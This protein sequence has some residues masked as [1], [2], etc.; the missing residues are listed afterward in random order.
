MDV[1]AYIF[2]AVEFKCVARYRARCDSLCLRLLHQIIVTLTRPAALMHGRHFD[3]RKAPRHLAYREIALT[4]LAGANDEMRSILL[5]IRVKWH[6]P[7]I[8]RSQR[9]LAIDINNHI[10]IQ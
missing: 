2:I 1:M 5:A 7:A 8:A 6:H 9:S 10:D 4:T 3:Q